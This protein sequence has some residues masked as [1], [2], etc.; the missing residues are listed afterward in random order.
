MLPAAMLFFG[1]INWTHTWMNP[2]GR[3]KSSEIAEL[4][5]NIFLDGLEGAGLPKRRQ[6]AEA[7]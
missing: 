2:K 3:A 4:A 5:A 6:R 1:M 7:G